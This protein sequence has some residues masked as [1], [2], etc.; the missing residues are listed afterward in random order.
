MEASGG[1]R[2]DCCAAGPAVSAGRASAGVADDLCL[3]RPGAAARRVAQPST[4]GARPQA[5]LVSGLV[6]AGRVAERGDLVRVELLLGLQHDA[7]VRADE[8]AY[9]RAF[10]S[11]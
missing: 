11:A 4:Q 10:T 1:G 6:V 8:R 2:A 3:V 5:A 7:C 9:G